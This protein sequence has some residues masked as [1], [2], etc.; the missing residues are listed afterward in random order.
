M[1][2]TNRR[3]P[4]APRPLS[5]QIP[6]VVS[7]LKRSAS[8]VSKRARSPDLAGETNSKR[9]KGSPPS[10]A[11]STARE[12]ERKERERKKMERDAQKEEFRIK[13]TR[14]FPSWV[15]YFDLDLLDPDSASAKEYLEAKVRQL[16][17]VCLQY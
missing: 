17:G 14:A 11:K 13:Y 3:P 9:V 5:L 15:F 6:S 7:P 4:L 10:P 16:G 12:D 2:T 8:G 1:A